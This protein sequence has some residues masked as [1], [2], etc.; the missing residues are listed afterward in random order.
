M[1]FPTVIRYLGTNLLNWAWSV[2]AVVNN[3]MNGKTNNT[4]SITL[5][6]S[7]ATTTV[8]LAEGRLGEDTIILFMPTTA[9]AATELASG[10]MYVSA[11]SVADNQF[12]ITHTNDANNDKTFNYIMVG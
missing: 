9:N 11:R 8:T 5:T 1:A 7:S 10:N 2:S 3:I 12:T 4:A 6:A